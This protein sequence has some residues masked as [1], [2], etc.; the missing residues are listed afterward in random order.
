MMN[1][2]KRSLLLL[3]ALL[4]LVVCP[5]A[6][7]AADDLSN[8]ES[9]GMPNIERFSPSHVNLDADAISSEKISQFVR[10]YLQVVNLIEQRENDLQAAETESE[11]I[12]LQRE[13]EL[14]ALDVIQA[15]GLTL[16]EYLQLLGLSNIDPEF[17]ERVAAQL[18]EDAN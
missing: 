18:Q 11:S 13:I 14:E 2:L 12:Q 3:L 9:A 4:W 5:I 16:Q 10:A 15:S 1:W 6:A 17:G 8:L 7:S